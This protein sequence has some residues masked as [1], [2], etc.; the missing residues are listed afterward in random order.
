MDFA[1]FW[2]NKQMSFGKPILTH[3]YLP[4]RRKAQNLLSCLAKGRPWIPRVVKKRAH[5]FRVYLIY[6]NSGVNYPIVQLK[7][8]TEYSFFS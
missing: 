8:L 3:A 1:Y 6:K 2:C 4:N 7:T 5:A